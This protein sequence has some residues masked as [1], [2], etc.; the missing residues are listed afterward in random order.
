[1]M[2]YLYRA[3]KWPKPSVGS[4]Q[5]RVAAGT[6]HQREQDPRRSCSALGSGRELLRVWVA[7]VC[8]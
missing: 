7:S 3:H 5:S 6:S 4:S 8:G 2:M 1:M